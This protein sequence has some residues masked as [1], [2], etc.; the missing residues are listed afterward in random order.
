[1][2]ML[3]NGGN[4]PDQKLDNL[5]NLALD[6]TEEE[7]EKSRNLNVGY[8]KQTRKWEII[9]KYSEMGIANE[10]VSDEMKY[11]AEND[12]DSVEILLGGPEISVVPLLGGYAIVTCLLYTSPSPRDLG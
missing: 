7:R 3:Q 5:L 1:M 12:R 11:G 9:V 2:H 10:E 8:E 4:M 6:A